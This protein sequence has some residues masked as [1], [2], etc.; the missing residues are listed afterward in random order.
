MAAIAAA[1]DRV[2]TWDATAV[3]AGATQVESFTVSGLR[4]GW[5]VVVNKLV[6]DTGLY[7][8][9]TQCPSA[10]TVEVTFFNP[11]GAEINPASQSFRVLQP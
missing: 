11:T 10:N 6:R 3:P 8:I 9:E 1:V 7:I 4:A 2:V 5:P